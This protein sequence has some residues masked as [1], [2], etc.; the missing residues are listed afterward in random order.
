MFSFSLSQRG[1]SLWLCNSNVTYFDNMPFLHLKC[2]IRLTSWVPHF[3]PQ[4]EHVLSG[5]L[6]ENSQWRKSG[7]TKFA[8]LQQSVQSSTCCWA[9]QNYACSSGTHFLDSIGVCV[10]SRFKW[11]KSRSWFQ[12]NSGTSIRSHTL[13]DTEQIGCK[14]TTVHIPKSIQQSLK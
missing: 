5:I 13:N 1:L 4:P 12:R 2:I 11:G 9:E 7:R 3:C 14:T 8:W 10:P 6:Q